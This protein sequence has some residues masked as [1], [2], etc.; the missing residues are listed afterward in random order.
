MI[1]KTLLL[2][3][4]FFVGFNIF[5]SCSIIFFRVKRLLTDLSI[6]RVSSYLFI[7]VFFIDFWFFYDLSLVSSFL[8][9][10][11]AVVDKGRFVMP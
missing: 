1:G 11:S 7:R 3:T 2:L 8:G 10:R 9:G 4:K 6:R 5:Q